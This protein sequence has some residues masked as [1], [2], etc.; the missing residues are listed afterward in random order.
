MD[1]EGRVDRYVL[2]V[3]AVWIIHLTIYI[4]M[5]PMAIYVSIWL[6]NQDVTSGKELGSV[7]STLGVLIIYRVLDRLLLWIFKKYAS[8]K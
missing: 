1:L 2:S 7:L 6:N 4:L 5:L 3:S 8:K